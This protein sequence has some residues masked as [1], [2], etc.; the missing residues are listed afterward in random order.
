MEYSEKEE[1]DAREQEHRGRRHD[2]VLS[3]KLTEELD[4]FQ[5]NYSDFLCNEADVDEVSRSLSN[6]LTIL[7]KE[8]TVLKPSDWSRILYGPSYH[9]SQVNKGFESVLPKK[10]HSIWVST[11]S[12]PQ[13]DKFIEALFSSIQRLKNSIKINQDQW[14]SLCNNLHNIGF[15]QWWDINIATISK[16]VKA[17]ECL[18][19]D[20]AQYNKVYKEVDRFYHAKEF[21]NAAVMIETFKIFDHRDTKAIF[22]DLCRRANEL[23]R[24]KVRQSNG[25]NKSPA[26]LLAEKVCHLARPDYQTSNVV[27]RILN[28]KFFYAPINDLA[29]HHKFNYKD[30]P[31]LTEAKYY[32]QVKEFLTR[33][34]WMVTEEVILYEKNPKSL[35]PLFVEVL[36]DES[37]YLEADSVLRRHKVDIPNA[38]YNRI[39]AKTKNAKEPLPYLLRDKDMFGPTEAIAEGKDPREYLCLKDFGF[40]E[41]DVIYID[42]IGERFSYA[43]EKLLEA[44]MIGVDAEFCTSL[45][46]SFNPTV[47]ILQIATESIVVIFDLLKLG[48][49]QSVY[50]LLYEIFGNEKILKIGHTL[51]SDVSSLRNTYSKMPLDFRG[52]IN[53]DEFVH[54]DNSKKTFG[55]AD[56]VKY[57]FSKKFCK[58][59]QQSQWQQRPLRRAQIHY[60]A[61]DSV[62]T[63]NVY[64][65]LEEK[66]SPFLKNMKIRSFVEKNKGNAEPKDGRRK[67][68]TR[69]QPHTSSHQTQN[70]QP[71]Q[72]RQQDKHH[73]PYQQ[74][75]QHQT[76]YPPNHHDQNSQPRPPR[77]RNRNRQNPHNAAPI[78]PIQPYQS[79]QR[80]LPQSIPHSHHQQQLF[81]QGR[82]GK[83]TVEGSNGLNGEYRVKGEGEKKMG[84]LDGNFGRGGGG[85][86][87]GREELSG[88]PA[89]SRSR[90]PRK[91]REEQVYFPKEEQLYYPKDAPS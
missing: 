54:P 9:F 90:R 2:N 20:D 30:Y 3:P 22:T 12:N 72:P 85:R 26:Q 27:I 6:I 8:N 46:P 53:I 44:P 80:P 42:A 87:G 15:K 10:W 38:L 45:K 16:Y 13:L 5:K 36:A 52:L 48:R 14:N 78:Q 71:Y 62:A 74:K 57:I 17:F 39:L 86:G 89:K 51:S 4:Y 18:P 37:M 28:A 24:T 49:N 76:P 82:G 34:S 58:Y 67:S 64:L 21:E 29:V 65:K 81:N 83:R 50:K 73:Q 61:L 66:K 47:S 40:A 32:N 88:R 68:R 33:T 7:K 77:P 31:Q 56:I 19:L 41:Q 1:Y 60:A 91:N 59:N 35:L 79:S 25:A 55:L 43:S 63:L 69:Q 23:D 84:G 75:Q 11:Q 70:P